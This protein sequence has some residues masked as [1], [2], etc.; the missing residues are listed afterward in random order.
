MWSVHTSCTNCRLSD[1]HALIK[2]CMCVHPCYSYGYFVIAVVVVAA[3][4]VVVVIM[5]VVFVAAVACGANKCT[6]V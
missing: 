1:P 5:A 3:V 4:V 6:D 2:I